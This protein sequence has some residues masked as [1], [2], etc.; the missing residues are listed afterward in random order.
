MKP[1]VLITVEGGIVQHVESTHPI[2]ALVCDIDKHAEEEV[3][4]SERTVAV[5]P[6][7]VEYCYKERPTDD[8]EIYNGD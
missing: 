8:E 1:K 4:W 5:F 2:E 7:H 3:S 6:N